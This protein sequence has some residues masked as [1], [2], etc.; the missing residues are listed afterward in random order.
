[1]LGMAEF[2]DCPLLTPPPEQQYYGFFPAYHVTA[3]LERYV[4]NHVYDG[5]SLRDRIRFKCCVTRVEKLAEG[6]KIYYGEKGTIVTAT[7]LMVATGLTSTPNMP[8]L[9][10][11][12]AFIAP[13]IHQKDLGQSS[14][15]ASGGVTH[16]T[17]LGGG[18][19]AADISYAAA[20]AGKKVAWIIRKGGA[21]PAAQAPA[22]GVAVYKNVNELLYNRLSSS[23]SPSVFLQQ[24][25][26][27]KFLHR[28]WLG[29]GLTARIWAKIDKGYR[30]VAGYGR[31][32]GMK[33]GFGQLEPDT[34]YV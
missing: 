34:P 26:L 7:R 33:M 24:S 9:S 22:K 31:H 13:I 29:R 8:I 20:K 2:S 30:K 4:D 23:F 6:W 15:L 32:D 19:S 3:Y 11:Q 5:R 10:N 25:G 1:M 16:V 21:G 27:T 14:I 18:K 28:T 17:I 12:D